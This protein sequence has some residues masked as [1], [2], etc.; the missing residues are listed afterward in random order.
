MN[1][2]ITGKGH[3]INYIKNAKISTM[4]LFQNMAKVLRKKDTVGPQIT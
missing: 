3:Q 1:Q 4:T 2:K